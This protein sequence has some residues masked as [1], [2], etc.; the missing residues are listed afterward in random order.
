M[1]TLGGCSP[2]DQLRR[3]SRARVKR[4]ALTKHDRLG[5]WSQ[6]VFWDVGGVGQRP[7]VPLL[8]LGSFFQLFF[9][10]F[11]VHHLFNWMTGISMQRAMLLVTS[12]DQGDQIGRIFAQWV[13]VYFG[14]IFENKVSH[15]F[16]LP[17]SKVKVMH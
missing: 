8:F 15:I 1:I 9:S 14:K 3:E 10:S 2:I 7:R 11:L 4:R 13:V 17:F 5:T 16:E 12:Q 6:G